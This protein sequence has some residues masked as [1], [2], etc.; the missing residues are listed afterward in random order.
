MSAALAALLLAAP[1]RLPNA[2]DFTRPSHYDLKL[3]VVPADGAFWGEETIQVDVQ[4][5]PGEV[6]LHAADLTVAE[7]RIEQAGKTQVAL[8]VAHPES[9]T[10]AL[11][12][13]LPLAPGPAT[14]WL[15]FS[16]KLRDDLRGL[17]LVKTRAGDLYAV[18]QFEATD[19]RRAFPCYDEPAFKATF[20]VTAEVPTGMTAISNGALRED[21]PVP[22][23][24][25]QLH[26]IAFTPTLPISSYLVALT[27]GKFSAVEADVP[28]SQ[29]HTH[30][31]VLA[32]TGRSSGHRPKFALQ[33][34]VKAL[35]WYE[36]YFGIPYPYP[37]LDMV[38]VP[39]FDAGGM[40]NAGAIFLPV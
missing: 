21:R 40:E 27:V 39:D 23:S 19:A 38:A 33:M 31:R 22:E 18:S 36:H 8:V 7:A 13:P 29:N 9:E 14:L 25:G 34:A 37:K 1:F 26:A 17:Y 24:P 20:S 6:I 32:P 11:Q 4:G 5:H 10:V 35:P 16:A 12:P 2:G 15:R 28:A 3:R 30:I